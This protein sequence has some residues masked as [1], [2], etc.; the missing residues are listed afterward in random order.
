MLSLS[1]DESLDKS[2]I[3]SVTLLPFLSLLVKANSCGTIGSITEFNLK[4]ILINLKNNIKI[5]YFLN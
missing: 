3:N 5:K 2:L 1:L 4:L